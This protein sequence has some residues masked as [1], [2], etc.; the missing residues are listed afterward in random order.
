MQKH[1]KGKDKRQDKTP[2]RQIKKK[3][4]KDSIQKQGKHEK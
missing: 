2:K 1:D 3:H 4:Q